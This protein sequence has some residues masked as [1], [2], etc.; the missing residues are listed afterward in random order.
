MK[1]CFVY[2]DDL[3][4]QLSDPDN[5][6]SV[7]NVQ[8]AP[9]KIT[10]DNNQ[11]HIINN[12]DNYSREITYSNKFNYKIAYFWGIYNQSTVF[13]NG[14]YVIPPGKTFSRVIFINNL[15]KEKPN[16]STLFDYAITGTAKF[17]VEFSDGTF[18][19]ITDWG[20]S[21][22]YKFAWALSPISG[23]TY[24][25]KITDNGINYY[26]PIANTNSI[27]IINSNPSKKI[28]IEGHQFDIIDVN[29]ARKDCTEQCPPDTI[30]CD[31]GNE[32]CCY[33]PVEYGY[34]LVKTIILED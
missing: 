32:R 28:Q 13:R 19:D 22:N 8:G 6:F 11:E 2:W 10:W 27:Q 9:Y 7:I 25:I 15:G 21:G 31:C 14:N 29:S 1:T 34:K 18:V 23:T 5:S 17:R 20:T 30:T 33:Q 16:Y 24:N 12:P 26:Y 3:S 4:Y